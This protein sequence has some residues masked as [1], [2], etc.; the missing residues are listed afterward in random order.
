MRRKIT[1]LDLISTIELIAIFIFT[2]ISIVL[3]PINVPL[4]SNF[5]GKSTI[6]SKY[7]FVVFPIIAFVVWLVIFLIS[8]KMCKDDNKTNSY[9]TSL[10]NCLVMLLIIALE[11]YFIFM[12]FSKCSVEKV[13]L[14]QL[15]NIILGII[16]I[17]V[18]KLL[19]LLS[20]NKFIGIRTSWSMYNDKTWTDSQKQGGMMLVI[21]GSIMIGISIFIHS[22]WNLIV[23]GC[24]LIGIIVFSLI[25]TYKL[26]KKEVAKEK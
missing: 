10:I 17:I 15:I 3:M 8:K 26:Y 1:I 18:G 22:F 2:A 25:I 14:Y 5:S 7:Y 4:H 16:Y 21:I 6:G 24:G 19:P 12:V 13:E 23:L 20:K 11:I 9:I